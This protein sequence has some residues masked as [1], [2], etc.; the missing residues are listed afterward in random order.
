MRSAE[1]SSSPMSNLEELSGSFYKLLQDVI[2]CLN[3][4]PNALEMLK[5]ALA[6]FVL[7][8]GDSKVASIVEPSLYND[9]KTV[10]ELISSLSPLINALS[11]NLL[12]YCVSSTECGL[13]IAKIT[14]FNHLRVSNSSLILCSDKWT[15][16]TT[17]DG[18]NDLNTTA[19]SG[20]EAAHT[21][22]L[23]QLQSVHPW[24]FARSPATVLSEH[25]I[26]ISV[27]V[28]RNSISLA[29]YDCLL[30]VISSL[31]GLPK[32]AFTYIG[33]TEE[34]L[35]LSWMV[36]K[37]LQ[38]YVKNRGGGVS[39]ECMLSEQGVVNLMV[40]DWLDYQCLTMNVSIIMFIVTVVH[41]M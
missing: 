39:G 18:L 40:G 32:C 7:P 16:P 37:E 17:P 31:F 30:T 24:V 33:C 6:S 19:T 41:V 28:N 13:A 25:C 5:H 38:M 4:S 21:A 15:V 12:Q 2:E 27:C 9:A 11:L 10:D 34:P 1:S 23:D 14:A 29:E 26:R 20:A 36:S 22:S 8:L 35:C 3:K